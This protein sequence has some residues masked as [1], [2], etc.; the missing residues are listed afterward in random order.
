MQDNLE[1]LSSILDSLRDNIDIQQ[2]RMEEF[3]KA[4]T[5]FK[6]N[7]SPQ[8]TFHFRTEFS[9]DEDYLEFASELNEFISNNKIEE[10]RIRTSGLYADIIKRIARE[11]GDRS[12]CR[13]HQEDSKGSRRPGPA[14]GGD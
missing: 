1:P 7:F 12:L 3:K 14:R 5:V 9:I 13:H 2:Q 4:V 6:S 8:N 10:Y 11:V